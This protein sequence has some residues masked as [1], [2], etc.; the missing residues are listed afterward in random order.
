MEEIRE[1]MNKE[2]NARYIY[3]ELTKAGMKP[4]ITEEEEPEE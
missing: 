1:T 4:E 2:S 3:D